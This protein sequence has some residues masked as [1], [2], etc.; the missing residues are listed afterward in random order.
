[1]AHWQET[2]FL[3]VV[4]E[5]RTSSLSTDAILEKQEKEIRL[6]NERIKESFNSSIREEDI[7]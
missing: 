6:L 4:S 3:E 5:I 1:M 2:G 7:E